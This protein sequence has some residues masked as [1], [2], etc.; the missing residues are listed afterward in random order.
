MTRAEVVPATRADYEAVYGEP[1]HCT[2]QG[3]AVRA[4][5]HV[6]VVCGL[7]R[8]DDIL[9]A[10]CGTKPPVP[11]RAAVEAAHALLGLMHARGAPVYAK[12]DM[13]VPTSGTL[14][15]HL[16]FKRVRDAPDGGVYRWAIR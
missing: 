3:F 2:F 14:L 7:Y 10:F 13:T 1:P 6:A 9:V 12:R 5:T 8:S 11:R 4:A 15:E 16:G